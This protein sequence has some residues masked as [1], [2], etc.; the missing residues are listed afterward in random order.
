[1]FIKTAHTWDF[2]AKFIFI[3]WR[4]VIIFWLNGKD[5][6]AM[7]VEKIES[8]LLLRI[9]RIEYDIFDDFSY[10]FLASWNC[11]FF[12]CIWI[13]RTIFYLQKHTK[14]NEQLKKHSKKFNLMLYCMVNTCL[15]LGIN[16]DCNKNFTFWCVLF[17]LAIGSFDGLGSRQAIGFL[18][19]VL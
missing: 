15:L 6:I 18:T 16:A 11:T 19:F 8:D 7:E 17:S 5:Y 4:A 3:A 12:N 2:V 14:K 13:F 9:L 1:M 10:S